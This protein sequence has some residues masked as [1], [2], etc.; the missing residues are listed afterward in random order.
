MDFE[1]T[2]VLIRATAAYLILLLINTVL[3]KQTLSQMSNHDFITA[4]MMGAIGANF[5]FDTGIN[6]SHT[7]T[8]LFVVAIIGYGTTFLSLRVRNVRKLVSGSPTVLVEDGKVLEE[9][10]KKQKYNMDSL[11]QSL[12]EK[13]IFDLEDVDYV[14][15]EPD[16]HISA[17]LK[18]HLRPVTRGDLFEERGTNKFPIELIMDGEIIEK[19]LNENHLTKEW[20]LRQLN[21]R[22]VSR[23][24][25][26]YAVLGTKG[27]LYIDVK[28]DNLLSP[29]DEESKQ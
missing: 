3:G 7:L 4:V 22:N 15:L 17:L 21:E 13:G 24:D 6:Y 27:Q 18:E 10:M 23:N 11:N 26:F 2:H 1:I 12:R 8:A 20:L 16:G 19:N 9:N 28:D 5:A 25:V 14:V 29:A